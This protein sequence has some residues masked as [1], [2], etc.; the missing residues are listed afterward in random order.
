MVTEE[1]NLELIRVPNYENVK[2]TVMP[3]NPDKSS[4]L[5]GF[6]GDFFKAC[7]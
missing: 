2:K 6:N 3:L 1:E 5:D 7:L 4:G